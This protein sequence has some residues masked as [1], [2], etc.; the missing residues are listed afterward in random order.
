MWREKRNDRSELSRTRSISANASS[1]RMYSRIHFRTHLP[2][3]IPAL[4]LARREWNSEKNKMDRGKKDDETNTFFA[5]VK[6]KSL[7]IEACFYLFGF[8]R[9]ARTTGRSAP[10][11]I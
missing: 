3:S 9:L 5:M 4:S 10:F 8:A 7:L 11:L 6:T 1:L 2:F